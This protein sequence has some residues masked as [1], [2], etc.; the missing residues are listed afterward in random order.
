MST[1][2][3]SEIFDQVLDEGFTLPQAAATFLAFKF[4]MF[5]KK[6]FKKWKAYKLGLIDDDG[7]TIKEPETSREKKAMNPLMNLIRKIKL[8][9]MKILPSSAILN[10]LIALYLLK[11]SA[12]S[13]T[14]ADELREDI[15]VSLDEEETLV[16][17]SILEELKDGIE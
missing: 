15:R 5:L 17:N 12:S 16:F 2:N 10:T 1:Y 13:V 11:E 7:K 8:I 6:D 9:M 4:A 3:I 14:N